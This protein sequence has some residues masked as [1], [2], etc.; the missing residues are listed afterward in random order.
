ME[1]A[2]D[3]ANEIVELKDEIFR[4]R[5]DL[6]RFMERSGQKHIET[7]LGDI[8][9]NYAKAFEEQQIESAKSC[10][11]S[12]MTKG[13][14]MRENCYKV[15]M[16]FLQGTAKHLHDDKVSDEIIN[17][18]R[19]QMN[20][21]RKKCTSEN[22]GTCFSEVF[23]LFEKQLDLMQSL[24]VY[25]GPEDEKSAVSDISEEKIVKDVL[26]PVSNVQRFQILKALVSESL[27][28][29]EISKMTGLR[30]GNLLFHIK[31]LTD[32]GMIFQRYERS[33]YIIT[34]KGYRTL[35]ALSGL[36]KSL[37]ANHVT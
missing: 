34:D 23:R 11:S 24:G 33:D 30:G 37:N 17:S 3:S 18:Y 31:K 22:C 32:S 16:D 2:F 25:S 4:L 19:E 14:A 20:E 8:K 27:S 12:N 29:S 1:A 10:L 6:R 36:Y 13:C 35:K 28:F 7:V 9:K 21:I 26:E 5:S 15:F